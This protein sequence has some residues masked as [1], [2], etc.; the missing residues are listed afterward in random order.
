[1]RDTPAL[2]W[3]MA[4]VNCLDL[5]SGEVW[6][7]ALF[8]M[9]R[10]M[11]RWSAAMRITRKQPKP[12]YI[13]ANPGKR[14]DGLYFGSIAFK[15]QPPCSNTKMTRLALWLLD[16][17]TRAAGHAAL[18]TLKIKTMK[19]LREKTSGNSKRNNSRNIEQYY[20]VYRCSSA[21]R[22]SKSFFEID[23]KRLHFFWAK[24]V[25]RLRK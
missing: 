23:P 8:K 10:D 1:M 15:V 19:E 22:S 4:G 20:P 3:K 17:Y 16:V 12:I 13:L 5:S 11:G 18:L 7:S 14:W 25:K 24:P 21:A 6:I 2:P 9:S